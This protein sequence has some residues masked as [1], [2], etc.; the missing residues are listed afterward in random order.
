[1]PRPLDDNVCFSCHKEL[2][3][4]DIKTKERYFCS[5]NCRE[6][7]VGFI[8]ATHKKKSKWNASCAN[9]RKHYYDKHEGSIAPDGSTLNYPIKYNAFSFESNEHVYDFKNNSGFV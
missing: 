8:I 5:E 2:T 3:C 4:K 9:Y 6:T 7:Y 1:M